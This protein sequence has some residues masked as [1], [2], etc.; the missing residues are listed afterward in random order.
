MLTR[1]RKYSPVCDI[2]VCI[3]VLAIG[4]I[5]FMLGLSTNNSEKHLKAECTQSTSAVASYPVTDKTSGKHAVTIY[6]ATITYTHKETG[7]VVAVKAPWS[8]KSFTEG[9][10]LNIRYSPDDPSK[11][12]VEGRKTY[13][14]KWSR[15]YM[16][17]GPI[18]FAASIILF[19]TYPA[20]KKKNGF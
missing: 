16:I 12:Y 1:Y 10:N 9:E 13:D 15:R 4:I 18:Y 3:L 7:E 19:L 8:S 17:G 11:I 5:M 2:L 20:R 14:E 6:S